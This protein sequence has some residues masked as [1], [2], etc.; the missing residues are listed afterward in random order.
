MRAWLLLLVL[1]ALA[2]SE[3]SRAVEAERDAEPPLAADAA[4]EPA[5]RDDGGE[6]A[7]RLDASPRAREGGPAASEDASALPLD[8]RA[9]ADSAPP[10][11]P[12]PISSPRRLLSIVAH[13][14][15]DLG[16]QSPSLARAVAAGSAVRTVYLTSGDAGFGCESYVVG[17]ERGIRLA[18][19][20][21][22]GLSAGE[23][24]QPDTLLELAGK[25]VRLVTMKAHPVSLVFVG[26]ANAALVDPNKLLALWSR[27]VAS[28]TTIPDARRAGHVDTYDR[29]QLIELLR[30]LIVDY[31]ADELYTLDSS[32]IFPP[33][34]PSD[35]VDHVAS[36]LFAL[37]ARQRA[38][39][40]GGLTQ[41]RGY[42][43][44]LEPANLS[45]EESALKEQIFDTYWP[46]D[47]KICRGALTT[48][49]CRGGG[50]PNLQVCD[51]R[52]LVYD[53]FVPRQYGASALLGRTG[54]V[55]GAGGSG[56]LACLTA[57][58]RD[59]GSA[60]ELAPCTGDESQ[61]F[62]LRAHGGITAY[63]GTL[64][65]SA[66]GE[67]SG[68]LLLQPCL[69]GARTQQLLLTGDGRL[70]GPDATCVRVEQVTPS[71][72]DCDGL[73]AKPGFALEERPPGS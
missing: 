27:Q 62:V 6:R 45:P 58:G 61:R 66:Q 57:K 22:L 64:C 55:R 12:E 42:N 7:I 20:R 23:H 63:D 32:R 46:H 47:A 36:A 14:D 4:S 71:V 68:P 39:V 2:C 15:D 51:D 33:D 70:R 38:E 67:S 31:R 24:W 3:R 40:A 43:I 17:R 37:A 53:G 5:R 48:D 54:V 19:E 56:E 8:A 49:V 50:G 59:P 13:E 26:L 16:L 29:E 73:P 28:L 30:A 11:P 34:L 18:Y 60:L 69:A 25:H 72:V 21:M 44:L 41:F 9:A 65:V 35:H 52:D 10:L 1:L